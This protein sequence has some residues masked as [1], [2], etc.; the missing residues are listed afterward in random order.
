MPN[1]EKYLDD[2]LSSID[3]EKSNTDRQTAAENKK[4]QEAVSRRT[5]IRPEDD[6]MEKRGLSDYHP[7]RSRRNNLRKALPESDYLKELEEEMDDDAFGDD[8]EDSLLSQFESELDNDEDE[9]S[10]SGQ[11]DFSTRD[12]SL[13]DGEDVSPYFAEIGGEDKDD[14]ESPTDALMGNIAS[15]VSEAKKQASENTLENGVNGDFNQDKNDDDTDYDQEADTE[16]LTEEP[17]KAPDEEIMTDVQDDTPADI[18]T[19]VEDQDA[20]DTE[21]VDLSKLMDV[22][23]QPEYE[24]DEH[25]SQSYAEGEDQQL[26]AN[27]DTSAKDVELMDESGDNV[28]LESI[29]SQNGDMTDIGDLLKADKNSEAIPEAEQQYEESAEAVSNDDIGDDDSSVSLDD[30]GGGKK[31]NPF[32]AIIEK[33]KSLFAGS[34]DDEDDENVSLALGGAPTAKELS[35]EDNQ[36]LASLADE[37]EKK[38]DKKKEKKAKKEKPK[39]EKK[40]KPAKAPKPKKEKKPKAPDNSPKVLVKVVAVFLILAVTIIAFVLVVQKFVPGQMQTQSAMSDYSEGK[41][42]AAYNAMD[43]KT[44]RN[45]SEEEF[46]QKCN[47]MAR[48]QLRYDGYK[49]GMRLNEY[50]YAL[51]S[52]ILGHHDYIKSYKEAESLDMLSTYQP[53]GDMI[54]QQLQDQFG[55]TE[56][57]AEEIYGKN[58]RNEYTRAIQ[59]VLKKE[60]LTNGQSAEGSQSSDDSNAS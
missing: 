23:L 48:L 14:T 24:P 41:Y 60:N 50:D 34:D 53:L 38:E 5:R 30:V 37:A 29:L 9:R 21:G 49:E 2:L 22:Q 33:I 3:H 13:P 40:P 46:Y 15:I 51:D 20:D 1:S 56:D 32:A 36:I 12:S 52:L 28:D 17:E 27:G 44:D 6:F 31:K 11:E 35:D 7:R 55:L 54:S 39:K 19:S 59:D 18:D 8:T 57:E 47:L 16:D 45:D 58:T 10:D 43:T 26:F 4:Q 42:L 25:D